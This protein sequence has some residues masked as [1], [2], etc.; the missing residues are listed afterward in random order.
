MN[1]TSV[2]KWNKLAT[3]CG[4]EMQ[5]NGVYQH[6]DIHYSNTLVFA[7]I[8]G[9]HV[10]KCKFLKAN[11]VARTLFVAVTLWD[12]EE[13]GKSSTFET[14]TVRNWFRISGHAPF[15]TQVCFSSLNVLKCGSPNKP[16]W[17][18]TGDFVNSPSLNSH[19]VTGSVGSITV[20]V[21]NLLRKSDSFLGTDTFPHFHSCISL[22][23]WTTVEWK[24]RSPRHPF[25]TLDTHTLNIARETQIRRW[26]RISPTRLLWAAL[27]V[28][29]R[30]AS[31]AFVPKMHS[32]I[33]NIRVVPVSVILRNTKTC[34]F[35][36]ND[37][38]I[39]SPE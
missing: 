2:V 33:N 35:S 14:I 15:T 17:R 22:G 26:S 8:L 34:H 13:P 5:A 32:V 39:C 37:G 10:S 23:I 28:C 21:A 25:L 12:V 24:L 27:Q 11:R 30:Q 29:T 31:F 1:S 16:Q 6:A 36:Y 3:G 20:L 38:G 4:S 19:T 9:S 18:V 7:H